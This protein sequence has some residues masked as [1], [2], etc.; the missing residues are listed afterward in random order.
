MRPSFTHTRYA[1]ASSGH[2]SI[3]Y[4]DHSPMSPPM[5]A[6]PTPIASATPATPAA[7]ATNPATDN[8]SPGSFHRG[9]RRATVAPPS[10][11]IPAKA[12]NQTGVMAMPND[13]AS[14]SPATRSTARG[15]VLGTGCSGG[16]SYPP[17]YTPRYASGNA[18]SRSRSAARPFSPLCHTLAATT[19]SHAATGGT[20]TSPDPPVSARSMSST[21]AVTPERNAFAR[22][23]RS[24]TTTRPVASTANSTKQIW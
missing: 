21:P 20:T 22:V 16:R 11:S 6:R 23:M 15:S 14:T 3:E 13:I 18:A 17:A 24:A 1:A 9:T 5:P 4:R 12:A 7:T 8:R 10:A 19:T 2:E